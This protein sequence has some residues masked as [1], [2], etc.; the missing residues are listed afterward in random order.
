MTSVAA[1]AFGLLLGV[2]IGL[3]QSPVVGTVVTA[4]CGL[5]AAVLAV[6]AGRQGS[7]EGKPDQPLSALGAGNIAAFALACVLG[8]LGGLTL[9]THQALSPS[10]ASLQAKWSTGFTKEE[11]KRLVIMELFNAGAVAVVERGGAAEKTA[12]VEPDNHGHTSLTGTGLFARPA[13][14]CDA[15]NHEL[16]QSD[17]ANVLSDASKECSQGAGSVDCFPWASIGREILALPLTKQPAAM[18]KIIEAA[19]LLDD[20]RTR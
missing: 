3:A 7:V 1:G 14:F 8:A 12:P 16:K 2:L 11:V 9:R 20:L 17:I 4:V 18:K 6:R 13:G 19:C 15:W 10:V 5:L